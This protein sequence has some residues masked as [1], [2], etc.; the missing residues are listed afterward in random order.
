MDG[1]LTTSHH[2]QTNNNISTAISILCGT[3]ILIIALSG[4]LVYLLFIVVALGKDDF[5]NSSYFTMAGWLGVADCICLVLMITYAAP[6]II[7]KKDLSDMKFIGGLLN[8]GWFTG[9]PLI[10]FLAVNRF[11]GICHTGVYKRWFTLRKT[12]CYCF[13]AL[14]FGTGYSV[15]S[16]M[17]Y[18]PLYFDNCRMSWQWDISSHPMAKVV[19]IGEVAI[20]MVVT[21]ITYCL[22]ILVLR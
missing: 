5:K 18:S 6:C 10:L 22:N 17:D 12:W 20:V 11:L 4:L 13:V 8:I 9:L 19:S 1:N 14:I 2:G 3:V 21:I 7:L 16:F 15:P